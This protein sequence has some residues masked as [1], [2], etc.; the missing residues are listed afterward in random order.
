M[1]YAYDYVQGASNALRFNRIFIFN[2]ETGLLIRP[3]DEGNY[4]RFINF[5]KRF[6]YNTPFVT[7]MD[8]RWTAVRI[9]KEKGKKWPGGIERS[10]RLRSHRIWK[11]SFQSFSYLGN[12]FVDGEHISCGGPDLLQG[13]HVR[14]GG[15][16]AGLS[17]NPLAFFT[18]CPACPEQSRIGVRCPL[19]WTRRRLLHPPLPLAAAEWVRLFSCAAENDANSR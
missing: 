6:L 2:Q 3:I 8:L 17:I 19:R 15:G 11:I 9:D 18:D 14:M 12:S 13:L 4:R 1:P 5:C 10:R 7:S 16:F